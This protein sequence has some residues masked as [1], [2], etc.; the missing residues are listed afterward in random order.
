MWHYQIVKFPEHYQL[1]EIIDMGELGKRYVVLEDIVGQ[2]KKDLVHTL[3]MMLED[4]AEYGVM[5]WEDLP[6]N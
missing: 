5:S 4:I 6:K 3:T 2:N 1:V